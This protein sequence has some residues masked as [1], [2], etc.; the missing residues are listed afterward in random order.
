M[1]QKLPKLQEKRQTQNICGIFE[2][3]KQIKEA[4]MIF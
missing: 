4:V 1:K 2:C 3:N